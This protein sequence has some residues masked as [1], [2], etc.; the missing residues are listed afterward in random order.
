MISGVEG[1]ALAVG[2]GVGFWILW[3]LYWGI[4]GCIQLRSSHGLRGLLHGE[5]QGRSA[6]GARC[7]GRVGGGVDGGVGGGLWLGLYG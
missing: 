6:G 3:I 1:L 2:F 7:I 5:H 4:A